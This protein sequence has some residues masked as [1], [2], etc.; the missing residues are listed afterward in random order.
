MLRTV[1]TCYN[2]LMPKH[3]KVVDKVAQKI[4]TICKE[5]GV[6]L[7]ANVQLIPQNWLSRLFIYTS[8]GKLFKVELKTWVIIE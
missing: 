4:A 5:S 6:K 3:S 1:K 2:I 8:L 7:R